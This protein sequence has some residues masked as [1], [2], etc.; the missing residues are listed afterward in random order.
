[1]GGLRC[2]LADRSAHEMRQAR[3]NGRSDLAMLARTDAEP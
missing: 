2:G 1:M 3:D